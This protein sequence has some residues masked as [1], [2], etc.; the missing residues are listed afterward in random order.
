[1]IRR[2]HAHGAHG[3]EREQWTCRAVSLARARDTFGPAPAIVDCCAELAARIGDAPAADYLFEELTR[4]RPTASSRRPP[5][6]RSSTSSV[7]LS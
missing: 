6:V 2:H 3:D 1:M 7:A 5:P 4:A